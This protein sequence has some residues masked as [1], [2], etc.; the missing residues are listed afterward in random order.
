MIW[1]SDNP[2]LCA[3]WERGVTCILR[4]AQPKKWHES[5]AA[6]CNFADLEV[7]VRMKLHCHLSTLQIRM[8]LAP[9]HLLS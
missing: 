9:T 1:S 7:K 2:E 8:T 3:I 6:L 4:N 5:T